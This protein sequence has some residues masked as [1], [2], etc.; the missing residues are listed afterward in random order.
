MSPSKPSDQNRNLSP[1]L[2]SVLKN[3]KQLSVLH[4]IYLIQEL[5]GANSGLG[6]VIEK[7]YLGGSVVIHIDSAEMEVLAQS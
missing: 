5:L 7:D 1:E 3:A 2:E 6:V 4:Q